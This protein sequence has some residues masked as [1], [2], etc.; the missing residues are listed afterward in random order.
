LVT[1]IDVLKA[2]MDKSTR[3]YVSVLVLAALAL[4]VNTL[5]FTIFKI[6]SERLALG[7]AFDTCRPS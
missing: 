4:I 1:D 3:N 5:V 2:T 7:F 6:L